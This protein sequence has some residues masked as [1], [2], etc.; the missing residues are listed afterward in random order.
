LKKSNVFFKGLSKL[1]ICGGVIKSSVVTD[2]CEVVDLESPSTTCQNPPTFP[3]IFSKAIGGQGSKARLV[4]CGGIQ[5]GIYSKSCYTLENNEWVSFDSMNSVRVNA[6]AAQLQ[7]GTILVTGGYDEFDLNS[8]EVLTELGWNSTIIPSLPV[9]I[10][11][12]CL[13][14]VNSTTVMAIGGS[15]DGRYSGKTY[16]FTF[17]EASWTD[18]PVLRYKR[19]SHS[20]GRI[21]R[22]TD[23]Q[24]WSI[25]VAGGYGGSSY[26]TSVEVL[27]GG[28]NQWRAG[29]KLPYGVLFSQM[30]EDQNGG[31]VLIGGTS[32][33]NPYLDAL[34]LLPHVGQD[35]AWTK[36]EQK[37]KLG[38]NTHTAFLVSDNNVDC[39]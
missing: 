37:L 19:E 17:G 18:G 34:L 23:S 14:T 39:S 21:R 13:V 11:E 31:V 2:T 15:Q 28:S 35:A 22:D 5:N 6:A 24:E 8:A 30:V 10:A 16:Y 27:D 25:I 12:H 33:T 26:M 36:M 29:P 3:A 32:P 1:L 4:I 7:D 38:K 9:T 20:C